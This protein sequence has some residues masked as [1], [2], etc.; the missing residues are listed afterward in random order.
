MEKQFSWVNIIT[1]AGAIVAYLIGSGFASGQ[2]AMQFFTSFGVK[3]CLGA[4][5]ITMCLYVWFSSTIMEDG[6]RLKLEST[7]QIFRYYCGRWIGGF[8]ENYT[9]V[10]LFLVFMV[11]IAGAGAVLTEY[12]GLNPQV[13]RIVMAVLALGT[14]LLG[15]DNLVNIV[16][17]I[18]PAII[19]F[20]IVLGFANIIM[21]RGGIGNADAVMENITVTKAAPAW[22]IS[23]VIFPAM[24]C[25]MLTPFLA[26]IGA[27]AKS[28]KEAKIGGAIGGFSF[29]LAVMLMAYGIMASIG[30][31]Y[32]KDVPSLF[33]ADK[34][35]PAV[36]VIFSLILFASI[37]TTAVPMLWLSCN[38]LETDEKSKKFRILVVVATIVAFIGGQLP[39]AKLVNIF[40]PITGYMGIVL[41]ICI[42]RKEILRRK[43][44]T[45]QPIKSGDNPSETWD[46]MV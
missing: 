6:R 44:K 17:K 25:M 30:D 33:I 24:G 29:V 38:R 27:S 16:S 40:Y 2:E 41:M 4:I 22:Y 39:F 28:K 36:G 23:G 15:L 26:G 37:Y 13:G 45:R 43:E 46:K 20:G 9:P 5:L 21:N 34:I 10:F 42:L 7:N 8:F 3:G 14:V 35:F 18:G 19:I 12:Y 1:F 11:M 32:M 31:L